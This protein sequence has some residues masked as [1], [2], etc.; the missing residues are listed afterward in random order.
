M[1]RSST[2]PGRP[3]NVVHTGVPSATASRFMV[4]PALI[5]RSASATSDWA[6]MAC[7]GTMKP[8]SCGPLRGHAR[9]HHGLRAAQPLQDGGEDVVLEAVVERDRRRRA[10]DGDRLAG[11]EAQLGQHRRVG[12]EVGEVVLLLQPG[13]AA[14]LAPRAVAV[15]ALGRDRLGHDDGLGQAAVDVCCTV[16]HS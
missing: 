1:R 10:H 11:I 5:T 12:L 14:Q 3:S 13:V 8:S 15:Q 2:A 6:S 7:S 16:A 4:P 9:E